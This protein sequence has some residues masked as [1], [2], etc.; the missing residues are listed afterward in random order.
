MDQL[1]KKVYQI[2]RKVSRN[3]E[4]SGPINEESVSR[5]EENSGS[6]NEERV[7]INEES[8]SIFN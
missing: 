1:T 8:V 4:N 2:T 5:N 7:S 6:I 3:E